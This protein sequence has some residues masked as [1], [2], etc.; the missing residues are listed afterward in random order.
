MFAAM[1]LPAARRFAATILRAT[2]T[3]SDNF[4]SILVFDAIAIKQSYRTS[5]ISR[6]QNLNPPDHHT[7]A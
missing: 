5:G 2:I 7:S 6:R 4:I 3:G 1:R